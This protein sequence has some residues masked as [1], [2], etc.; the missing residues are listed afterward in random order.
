MIMMKGLMERFFHHETALGKV[1]EKAKLAEEELFELKNWK[2]VIEQK[3]KLAEQARDEFHKLKEELKKTLED[4]ENEVRQAK[5]VALLE[6][7]DSDALI[8]ELEVSYNDGFD[9]AIRQVKALYPELDLSSV[10]ISV[11]EPTSVHP[12]QSEDT[13]ELFGE[14]VPITNA[15]VVLTVEEESKNE[16]ASQAKESVIL[17]ASWRNFL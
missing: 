17:D 9:D 16:E 12:D 5:E 2:L 7:R 6:Y 4:K 8:S 10:N 11:P 13:N 15:P 3:F 1:R 14:D